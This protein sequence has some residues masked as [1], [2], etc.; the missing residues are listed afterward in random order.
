MPVERGLLF[1]HQCRNSSLKGVN[2]FH[3]GGPDFPYYKQ[4]VQKK[5][6]ISGLLEKEE[7]WGF[8]P[9]ILCR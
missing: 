4:Y 6:K 5:K 7:L 9:H 8:F 2:F 1:I 3:V